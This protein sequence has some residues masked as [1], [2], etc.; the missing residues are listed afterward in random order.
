MDALL[1]KPAPLRAGIDAEALAE[2]RG[3][4]LALPPGAKAA[5]RTPS[6]KIEIENP[7]QRHPLPRWLP[8]H[9]EDGELPFRLVTGASV[10]GLNSSFRERPELRERE[11]GPHSW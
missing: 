4:E 11:G 1:A 5:F 10:W 7:R 3:V 6:G 2:G 9:E 8:S